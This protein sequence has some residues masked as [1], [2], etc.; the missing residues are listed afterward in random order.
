MSLTMRCTAKHE[1][2]G[3]QRSAIISVTVS[4]TNS[5]QLQVT[6]PPSSAF[7]SPKLV[8]KKAAKLKNDLSASPPIMITDTEGSDRETFEALSPESKEK[9]LRTMCGVVSE[10]GQD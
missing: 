8:K 4:V 2:N 3:P 6:C 1:G 5:L 7:R 9:F 10:V